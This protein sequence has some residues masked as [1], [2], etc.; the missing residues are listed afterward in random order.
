MKVR[1]VKTHKITQKDTDILAVINVYL[2]EMP[3]GSVLAVTSKIVSLCEGRVIKKEGAEKKKLVEQEAEMYL[4]A[5]EN[6][7]HFFLAVKRGMLAA[8]AGIDESN[9]SD[10]YVFWPRDPQG[11]ADSIREFLQKRFSLERVGVIITDSTTR[12]LRWGVNGI[13]ISHSG[14]LALNDYRGTPDLFGRPLKVTQVNVADGL[15]SS[16]VLEMGEGSE[17]TP[18]AVIEDVP[19]VQFQDRNPSQEE[20]AGL[21]I[22]LEE[23][24]YASILLRAP[25]KKGKA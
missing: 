9:A 4:P 22:S 20:L 13:A 2:K 8:T 11:S 7:H 6:K 21:R 17:Q 12:P 5:D 19:F 15:A 18:L 24:L 25:W 16:A 3:E 14:F 1:T 10:L 23:D